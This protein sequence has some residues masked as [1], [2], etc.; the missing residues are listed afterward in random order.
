MNENDQL[1]MKKE[2]D[3]LLA[4]AYEEARRPYR[5]TITPIPEEAFQQS[6]GESSWRYFLEINSACNL[7]CSMCVQS[8]LTGFSHKNGLMSM[9]LFEGIVDKIQKEN[10]KADICLYGNSEPFIHPRLAQCIS[11]VRKRGLSCL[12]STNFNIITMGTQA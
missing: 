1:E 3:E 7:Q 6:T 5:E 4:R 8:D 12:V 11:A 2:Y 10:S 9:E